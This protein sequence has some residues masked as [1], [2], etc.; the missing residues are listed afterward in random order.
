MPSSALMPGYSLE[1]PV[2]SGMGWA[3]QSYAD[4]FFRIARRAKQAGWEIN[5]GL[6]AP[7]RQPPMRDFSSA[8]NASTFAL[9]MILVG[10][11][12]SLFSGTT[13][14]SPSRYLAISFMPW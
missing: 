2:M 9:S 7:R 13:D 4:G 12:I 11:M 6:L 3:W 14:L 1:I 10:T 5:A 8:S